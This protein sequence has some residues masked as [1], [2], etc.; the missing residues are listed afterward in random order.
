MIFDFEMRKA[1]VKWLAEF[2]NIRYRVPEKEKHVC[3]VQVA[4]LEF[5]EDQRLTLLEEYMQSIHGAFFR[6]PS[7]DASESR[8]DAMRRA[9]PMSFATPALS[10]QCCAKCGQQFQSRNALFRHLRSTSSACAST[11]APA[12]SAERRESRLQVALVVSY[13]EKPDGWEEQLVAASLR[14]FPLHPQEPRPAPRVTWASPPQRGPAKANVLGMRLP[15]K[16]EGLEGPEILERIESHL[17]VSSGVDLLGCVEVPATFHAA[18]SCE[19]ERFEA[20]LPWWILGEASEPLEPYSANGVPFDRALARRVKSGLRQLRAGCHWQNFCDRSLGRGDPPS[21]SLNRLSCTVAF[22]GWCRIG[23][24][25][26]RTLPGMVDR[27]LGALVLWCRGDVGT[28]FLQESL[29]PRSRILVP[30]VPKCCFYLL[31]PH[32]ARF[33]HKHGLQLTND[34]SWK[35]RICEALVP[36][37][38]ISTELQQLRT[39]CIVNLRP[40]KTQG[41][42]VRLPQC[43]MIR[44]TV[45]GIMAEDAWSQHRRRRPQKTR[46]KTTRL[47]WRSAEVRRERRLD[48]QNGHDLE[49]ESE[50]QLA[51][52]RVRQKGVLN[53]W[54]E[55]LLFHK[56]ALW[57]QER[58]RLVMDITGQATDCAKRMTGHRLHHI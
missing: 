19:I 43:D 32:M 26:Q 21:F 56:A 51:V 13:V 24:S 4:M 52:A 37:E 41:G 45:D 39:A 5:S 50:R 40:E 35:P 54:R 17:P 48:A 14:A 22:P 53:L 9:V 27:L 34:G 58:P 55:A 47:D 2:D 38:Q 25:V 10:G 28:T 49:R 12:P 7:L 8:L 42:H 18:R 44:E 1:T 23:V 3:F 30:K 57:Q 16:A 29:A 31:Q 15:K 20:L 11:L 36:L 46:R 6:W 33:E